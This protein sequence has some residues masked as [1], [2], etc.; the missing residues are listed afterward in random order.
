[1]EPIEWTKEELSFIKEHPTIKIGVDPAFMPF[2]FIDAEGNYQGI[3]ADYIKR[4]E[5]ISGI[6]MEVVRGITWPEAY[7]RALSGEIDVLPAVTQTPE[8]AQYFLFSEPYYYFQR[9]I[10]TRDTQTQ[11]NGI[12]DL[13]GRTVAVQRNSSHYSYLQEFSNINI[14]TYESVEAA[15]TAVADGTEESFLGNLTTSNYIIQHY[16]LTN[17][18]FIA[19]EADKKQGIQFAVR[20]DWPL[21]VT[22]IN[23][24]LDHMTDQE[25]EAIVDRWVNTD[26]KVNYWPFI[27]IALAVAL[28]LLS[29]LGISFY[30]II[31]MKKEI[32]YRQRLQL[33]LERLTMEAEN[34]NNVKSRFLARM[35][36]EIRTPLN[37][38]M[39]MSYLMK[40]TSMTTT[41]RAYNDR[42][43]QSS[44]NMLSIINDILDFA[45]MEAD[46]IELERVSFS[47]DQVIQDVINIVSYKIDEKKLSF[48]FTKDPQL[49]N[50][51]YGD[52][53]R[54]EQILINLINNAAK[55]TTQGEISFRISMITKEEGYCHL[56]FGIK[57]TGVGMTKEQIE[58]LFEP[59]TQADSSINRRFGGT[60]LGLSI[61]KNLVEMMNGEIEVYSTPMEGSTFLVRLPLEMDQEREESYKNEVSSVYFR[62]IRSLVLEKTGANMDL[63]DGYLRA[64]GM[65][66]EMTS[67]EASVVSMLETSED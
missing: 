39:G 35:S 33:E 15:L 51:Y 40:K 26:I 4:I 32:A 67:S 27:R 42:I 57:D 5:Q 37:A 50:W 25:K 6:Q 30:W 38:I 23:K 16:G 46:K 29:I 36:H 66:C 9:V 31:R 43:L 17:L 48:H 49:P 45:K 18:K 47:L 11:I 10:V 28:I 7:D 13:E 22:I 8:R 65:F 62:D 61:V 41:Q 52:S 64:F 24:S 3:A 1:M 20:N 53:K 21:L 44:N 14:S 56:R 60:G 12:K 58:Q 19:F 59:F 55:F 63:I 54:I 34:A 2:E